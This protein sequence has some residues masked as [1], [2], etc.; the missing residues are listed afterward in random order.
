MPST[1][2][3]RKGEAAGMVQTDGAAMS[4]LDAAAAQP[5]FDGAQIVGR[6]DMV[7]LAVMDQRAQPGSGLGLV[8]EAI[9]G[10]FGCGRALEQLR[11]Q[12]L[13]SREQKRRHLGRNPPTRPAELVERVI[14]GGAVIA[15]GSRRPLQQQQRVVPLPIPGRGETTEGR[16][17][18]V[19]PE[20][21]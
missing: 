16:N 17:L 1:S 9:E 4:A 5:L 20:T 2:V 15:D 14:P 7:P 3:S 11:G 12:Q 19:A 10:K 13:D 6:A 18:A 8:V 21:V